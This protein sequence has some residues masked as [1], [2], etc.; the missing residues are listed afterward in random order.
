MTDGTQIDQG[1]VAAARRLLAA[2][3]PI[4]VADLVEL[5]AQEGVVAPKD[6]DP[7]RWVG[8]HLNVLPGTWDLPDRRMIDTQTLFEG[9]TLT[10]ELTIT[11]I[12]TG[13][14]TMEPDLIPLFLVDRVD[15]E[16]D[17]AYVLL[18]GGGRGT[19]GRFF[20]TS[21]DRSRDQFGLK[22]PPEW[23]G[24]ATDG[25]LIAFRVTDGQVSARKVDEEPPL[26]QDAVHQL[27]A[28]YRT[29]YGTHAADPDY[30]WPEPQVQILDVFT[31]ALAG[32]PSLFRQPMPPLGV[33]FDAGGLRAE[34]RLLLLPPELTL[35]DLDGLDEVGAA[36]LR[37]LLHAYELFITDRAYVM[38]TLQL[39]PIILARMLMGPMVATAFS[40][41]TALLRIQDEPSNMRRDSPGRCSKVAD[42][43]PPERLAAPNPKTTSGT[44][45]KRHPGPRFDTRPVAAFA[46][47]LLGDHSFNAGPHLLLALC[48]DARGDPISAEE[49]LAE[50]LRLQPDQAETLSLA[51]DYAE[52]RSDAVG[53]LAH[54]RNA[55]AGD[56]LRL[57]RLERFAAPGPAVAA[58]G[59]PCPCGSGRT[60]GV[61]CAHRNGHPCHTRAE[62]LL[63]KALRYLLRP[64]SLMAIRAIAEARARHDA[65]P[66]AWQRAALGDPLT[67]DLGLFEGGVLTDFLD[68]RGVLLPADELELGRGWAGIRRRLYQ[69]TAVAPDERRITLA[70]LV[71]GQPVD[72]TD[73]T[74]VHAL[75]PGTLLYARVV[76][77][78]RGHRLTGAPLPIPTSLRADVL[79]LLDATAIEIAAWFAK[80]FKR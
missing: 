10:H 55:G 76:P 52:D 30:L 66:L 57:R 68:V 11:E 73:D 23:L 60:H 17:D 56:R 50:A 13:I 36:G 29:V 46:E 35:T 80:P 19:V 47:T 71:S 72:V 59:A 25:D 8:R 37:I 61:C 77:D 31:V 38:E 18:A 43:G 12:A 62:W 34:G 2:H 74:A 24:Q 39:A 41:H 54:L 15:P 75:D 64:P 4:A 1:V 45:P 44:R 33:L 6:E 48:A 27:L 20:L 14:I 9:L 69:I 65:R 42:E 63:A 78:G 51:A 79:G 5:L 28:A 70:D 53:A 58:R 7:L 49:H 3:Q 16:S 40:A 67:Q 22:V 26:P 32:Q 21:Q